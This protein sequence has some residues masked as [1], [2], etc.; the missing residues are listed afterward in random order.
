MSKLSIVF[1]GTPD[2]ALPCLNALLHSTHHLKAVYT[3]PD[4]PAGRGRKMQFSAVKQWAIDN[5]I[6]VYQPL[7]FKD[8]PAVD[9]L[10]A[11]QPDVMIVIAYGLILPQRVL[12]IPNHGCINVHASLLPRW[13][14]ASPIQ[15]AILH[16]DSES[17]VT[18]MQMS[19]GMDTGD[20]LAT[21]SCPIN[22][23]ETAASLHDKL[24]E[25]AAKPLITTLDNLIE[26]A[27]KAIP[28]VDTEVTY[29][30]KI[31]KEDGLINWENSVEQIHQQIRA[32]NPWPIA[33]THVD[34][35]VIRIY[36]AIP[37]Q[38]CDDIN[39]APGTIISINKEGLLLA[40]GT[41][42]LLVQRIQFSGGKVITIANWLNSNRIQL[43]VGMLL[44]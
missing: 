32:Y 36:D 18:I 42:P 34:N 1:A 20:M 39:A 14:G 28:Q 23:N 38:R 19:A 26:L 10:T 27:E 13:R 25:L 12:D 15:Q 2:F 3:Q 29:A 30:G 11:L 16:G 33:Y 5:D 4:R 6:P 41:Q 37:Y 43:E 7:N 22:T 24:S 17:G 9:E 40:T 21:I 31:K 44:K 8:S 35:E